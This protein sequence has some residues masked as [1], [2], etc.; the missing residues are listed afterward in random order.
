MKI[1]DNSLSLVTNIG[2]NNYCLPSHLFIG[3]KM[4]K[5]SD[6]FYVY[7]YLDPRKPGKY[8]YGEY[9]FDYEPFYVG[10]GLGK[11]IYRHLQLLDNFLPKSNKIKKIIKETE[12][13]PV[14]VK[15][16]ENLTEIESFDLERVLI[17]IIGRKDLKLGP[18]TNLT[19]GGEGTSGWKPS[20]ETLLNMGKS[21]KGS[22]FSENHIKNLS[23]SLSGRIFSKEHCDNISLGKKGKKIFSDEAKKLMSLNRSGT[24]HPQNKYD[25]ILSNGLNFWKD[26]THNQKQDIRGRFR[27]NKTTKIIYKG[28]TITKIDK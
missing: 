20:K 12:N 25:Y 11:R 19:Y 8:K 2:V 24:K 23:K 17:K 13:N 27:K 6:K 21:H 28:I 3:Y 26:L 10:K 14:I 1:L 9:E 15:F 7:I 22:I 4:N 5:S 18:L 16:K